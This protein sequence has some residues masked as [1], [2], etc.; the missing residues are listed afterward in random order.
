M[1]LRIV[2]V[3]DP[4]LFVTQLLTKNFPTLCEHWADSSKEN[5]LD[6]SCSFCCLTFFSAA[7]SHLCRI[8]GLSSFQSNFSP[9]HYIVWPWI[10][11]HSTDRAHDCHHLRQKV[12][13]FDKILII[14]WYYLVIWI[15][16]D[17]ALTHE[18][19]ST[20]ITSINTTKRILL[21]FEIWLN[22]MIEEEPDMIGCSLKQIPAF[23]VLHIKS[24]ESL[25]EYKSIS[26]YWQAIGQV[27]SP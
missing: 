4:T 18:I 7:I 19:D 22:L 16:S 17:T 24:K 20:K 5:F 12:E 25:I 3:S 1:F 26:G 15:R 10:T 11:G 27:Q 21:R 14:I 9:G 13:N 23:S 6:N 2:C 8:Q